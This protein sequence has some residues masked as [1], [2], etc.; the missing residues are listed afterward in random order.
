MGLGFNWVKDVAL[1]GRMVSGIPHHKKKEVFIFEMSSLTLPFFH[2]PLANL[3]NYPHF[4]GNAGA[5][6]FFIFLSQMTV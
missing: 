1:H 2:T 3:F 6:L 5:F 4:Y